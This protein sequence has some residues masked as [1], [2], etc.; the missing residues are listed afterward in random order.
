MAAMFYSLQEAAER[1]GKTE[2]QIRA[3]VQSGQ[4]R[5]FRD[6]PNLLFKVD[7]VNA[8]I[9]DSGA[10]A[11]QGRP[12]PRTAQPQPPAS[13]AGRRPPVPEMEIPQDEVPLE[14]DIAEAPEPE[15]PQMFEPAEPDF[16]V[17]PEFATPLAEAPQMEMPE[18]E[19]PDAEFVEGELPDELEVPQMEVPE[20]PDLEIPELEAPIP[21]E[22]AGTSEI[23]LA[24][25]SSTLDAPSELTNADTAITGEG[26]S[27][28]GE[29]DKD[30]AISDDTLGE[31]IGSLG[32]ASTGTTP[33]ASLEEIEGDVNLDSFGSG[34]GLLDLSLQADDTSLGGILDEIYTADEEPVEAADPGTVAEV[35][36]EVDQIADDELAT[37]QAGLALP[38]LAQARFEA[39]PD[40]ASNI[41]GAMLFVPLF[42]VLYTAIV[43]VGGLRGVVPSLLSATQGFIWYIVI[44]FSVVTLGIGLYA[45]FMADKPAAPARKKAEKPK[46]VKKPKK[47][48]K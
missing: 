11:F 10:A 48:K 37:V 20:I 39:E 34:S 27:V 32:L 13:Q 21:Q 3:I 4:L 26:I 19:L 22:P 6:G 7:E 14:F 23:L 28:L 5:E 41:L 30:Y 25:E 12:E 1:L 17:P 15:T 33:D 44:G 31:T 8:L 24:P 29:T 43:A 47:A 16:D 42:F 9:T 38:G 18:L 46:K 35:T 36:A 45:M 40:K 2:D